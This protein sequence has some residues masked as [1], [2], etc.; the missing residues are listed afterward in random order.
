[1]GSGSVLLRVHGDTGT[2]KRRTAGVNRQKKGASQR[3]TARLLWRKSS[4]NKIHKDRAEDGG[5]N[6]GHGDGQAAH[7]TLDLAHLESLAGA[8][9]MGGGADAHTL[10]DG[11][12]DVEDLADRLGQ[13]VARD[14]GEDDDGTGKGCDAAQLGGNIHA[15][16]CGDG[17]G[18]QGDV[19]LAGQVHGD[20]QRQG[21]AEADQRAHRDARDDGGGVLLEQVPLLIQRDGKADGGGQQQIADRGRA[22]LVIGVGDLQHAEQDDDEDAAQQQRVEERLAG[23]FVDE[24]AQREGGQRQQHAPRGGP[25]EEAL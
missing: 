9:G 6:T 8:D 22:D 18:Q 25:G 16:G 14:A 24:G 13:Q 2:E 4:T 17:F 5:E 23:H 3:K 12:G 1:M 15:D 21:T 20:G 19:L 10:G 11:V 7:G